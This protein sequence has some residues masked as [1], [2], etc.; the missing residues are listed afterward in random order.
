MMVVDPLAT[1]ER[2]AIAEEVAS[3][4]RHDLRNK[5]AVVRNAA[6]FIR[7]R[8][9]KTETWQGD[10]R[11][12]TFADVID[13]E[14][15]EANAMLSDAM[16]L[17]RLF[18]RAIERVDAARCLE[19]ATGAARVPNTCRFSTQAD[20][21]EVNVDA[22]ELALALRCLLENAAEASAEP[23]GEVLVSVHASGGKVAIAVSDAGPGIAPDRLAD[24]FRPF[25]TTKD[26]HAGLGLNIARRVAMRYGGSLEIAPGPTGGLRALLTLPAANAPAQAEAR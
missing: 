24:A 5:L 2:A 6:S 25:A 17:R 13:K 10:P 15:A 11:L 12:E 19:V 21:A 9:G 1:A 7:K 16:D 8:L 18:A 20:A 23:A 22:T 4:L 14:I 26:G 3:V